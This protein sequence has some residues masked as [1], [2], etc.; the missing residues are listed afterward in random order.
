MGAVHNCTLM[1]QNSQPED[2]L[3]WDAFVKQNRDCLLQDAASKLIP[4]LPIIEGEIEKPQST[5]R[6]TKHIWDNW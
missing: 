5:K 4:P 2:N 1:M 6:R 3:I